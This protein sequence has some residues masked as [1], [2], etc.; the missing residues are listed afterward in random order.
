MRKI[1]VFLN[2]HLFKGFYKSNLIVQNNEK[3]SPFSYNKNQRCA[4]WYTC[5]ICI[6]V[7]YM[8]HNHIITYSKGSNLQSKHKDWCCSPIWGRQDV[9]PIILVLYQPEHHSIQLYSI[10]RGL[11]VWK[12]PL[13]VWPIVQIRAFHAEMT[14]KWNL[15]KRSFKFKKRKYILTSNEKCCF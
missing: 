2:E 13:F 14:V 8:C 15:R 10:A 11:D 3:S 9:L 5:V 1:A 7:S 12:F 6:C 4:C